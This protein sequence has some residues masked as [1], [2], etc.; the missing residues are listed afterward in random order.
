[1]TETH[2]DPTTRSQP[3]DGD[4]HGP[5]F[6]VP[7]S[8]SSGATQS[9]GAWWAGP[10]GRATQEAPAA[11]SA[12]AE[13]ASSPYAAPTGSL[14]YGSSYDTG[15]GQAPGYGTPSYGA[16]QSAYAPAYDPFA[17]PTQPPAPE[18]PATA[19]GGPAW[20]RRAGALALVLAVA[21]G[22]GT[23]G[24]AISQAF[25][26]DAAPV[27]AAAA[28]ATT[29]SST[30]TT[31]TAPTQS[32][33]QVA[34]KVTPSVVSVSFTSSAGQ[35]EGSGVVL[36]A[37]GQILTN[38]HVVAAAANGGEITVKFADGKTAKASILGRDPS[39]DLAVIKAQ[40]VSGLT[41]ATIGKSSDLHVGDTVLAIGNPLGLEGS[42][43][44]G[45]VS[46]L[47]RSVQIPAEEEQQQPDSMFPGQGQLPQTS[48]GSGGTTLKGAI[49]TDAAVNPGNSGGALVDAAGRVVGINSAIASLSSGSGESGSIGVGFAIPIDTA[50]KV[51]EQ[52]AKGETVQHPILGV[53]ITDATN[54]SAG[55]QIGTVTNGSGAAEAGL[56][57]GDI[58]TS[59]DGSSITDSDD[60]TATISTHSVGDQV[61]VTYTRDGQT[62]TATVTLGSSD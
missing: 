3:Y 50:M 41:P 11:S 38:N 55:A 1:M 44:A 60:L 45:I 17:P 4:S 43:S 53:T 21:L 32:L 59:V 10:D 52:L 23:A 15:Y 8:Y 48:T 22:S 14:G 42:V 5:D 49:Q 46:A 47:G 26:D 18:Q 39:T 19:K 12:P 6:E 16:T 2:T 20:G 27:A 58:I 37:D 25:D 35:G 9:S 51:A 56:Q 13:Q 24:A 34:A 33:A 62:R 30:S 57:S 54:G 36:T 61:T 29:G 7:A 31:T 40:N 28:P